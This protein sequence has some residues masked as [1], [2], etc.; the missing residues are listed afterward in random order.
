MKGFFTVLLPNKLL[1]VTP[2]EILNKTTLLLFTVFATLFFTL[3]HSKMLYLKYLLNYRIVLG[4]GTVLEVTLN[5]Y[6]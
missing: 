1:Y 5:F 2:I 6:K 4:S 3:L